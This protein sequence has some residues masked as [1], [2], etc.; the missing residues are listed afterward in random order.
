MT[1]IHF[2]DPEFYGKRQ[3]VSRRWTLPINVAVFL[4]VAT[5]AAVF[6]LPDFIDK[7][8]LLD[9]TITVNLVSLPDVAPAPPAP[10]PPV[11]KPEPK[12]EPPKP[13]PQPE[14]EKPQVSIAEPEPEPEPQ[15]VVA[16]KPISLQPIKRKVKKK[17]DTRLEEEKRREQ[18][19]LA[20]KRKEAEKQKRR[21]AERRRQLA[22][23]RRAKAAAEAE[24]RA[25]RSDL[26]AA[27][28]E[29]AAANQALAAARS[30]G[31]S[32][33]G[34]INNVVLQNYLAA[35]NAQVQ[36]NWVLPQ[37]RRFSP[38]LKTL[39]YFT[40]HK[41]GQVADIKIAQKSGDASFDTMVLKTVRNSIPFPQFPAL[42]KKDSLPLSLGF[43]PSGVQ[44]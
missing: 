25:A 11:A 7:K 4:H 2:D 41:N 43:D 19:A 44:G 5:F 20:Q 24:A 42:L 28:R 23:A 34:Q 6:Y 30:G 35:I 3:Q 16:A 27:I 10:A 14:L 32:T 36:S 9:E 39:V 37:G 21:E 26:A 17:Q 8:P 15:P 18:L 22:E 29:S 12:P 13:E 38:G 1:A 33:G 40:V 31:G